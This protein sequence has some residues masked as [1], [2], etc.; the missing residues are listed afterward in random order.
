MLLYLTNQDNPIVGGSYM[1]DCLCSIS[2]LVNLCTSEMQWREISLVAILISVSDGRCI[3]Y[4]STSLKS[5]S[6]VKSL[7]KIVTARYSH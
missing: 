3:K 7:L 4:I 2:D 1:A 6:I 5:E